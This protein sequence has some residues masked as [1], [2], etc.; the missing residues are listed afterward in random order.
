VEAIRTR[1]GEEI[2][3]TRA[4]GKVAGNRCDACTG[5]SVQ[6][7]E[8]ILIIDMDSAEVHL[9]SAHEGLLLEKLITNY[10]KRRNRN[11]KVGFID[12]IEKTTERE[13]N[14]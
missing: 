12:D 8:I 14:V 2:S 11:S 4:T 6:D 10:L 13:K 7:K 1:V 3:L 5:R 9:C